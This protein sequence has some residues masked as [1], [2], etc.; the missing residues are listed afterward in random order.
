VELTVMKD[1]L[2]VNGKSIIGIMML[3][4]GPGSRLLIRAVGDQADAALQELR[5][6]IDGKF[7]EE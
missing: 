4:A 6:L 2:S 3:A 1:S 5:A 7:G